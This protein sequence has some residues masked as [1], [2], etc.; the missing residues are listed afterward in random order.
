MS[1]KTHG[2]EMHRLKGVKRQSGQ[3]VLDGVNSPS[4]IV[5]SGFSVARTGVGRLV[6]TFDAPYYKVLSATFTV[7]IAGGIDPSFV[8]VVGIQQ[9]ATAAASV[10]IYH[11]SQDNVTKDFANADSTGNVVHFAVDFLDIG[12][13]LCPKRK[14]FCS[15]SACP[16]AR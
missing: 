8:E 9:G 16:R 12:A 10:T 1:Q 11:L 15:R 6:I 7:Q 13:Q 3:F 5:G 4:V 2:L 14:G